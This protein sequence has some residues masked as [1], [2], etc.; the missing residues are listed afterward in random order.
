[1]DAQC[2]SG[3][4]LLQ[5]GLLP[6]A[7]DPADDSCTFLLPKVPPNAKQVYK[8]C[9]LLFAHDCWDQALL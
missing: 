3:L 7:A 2:C 4:N 5:V 1:M 6:P 9:S 8:K